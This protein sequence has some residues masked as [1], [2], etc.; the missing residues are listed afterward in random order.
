MMKARPAAIDP[1]L[2]VLGTPLLLGFK[3]ILKG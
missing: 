1:I 3:A 2:L